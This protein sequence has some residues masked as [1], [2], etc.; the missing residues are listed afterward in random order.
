MKGVDSYGKNLEARI[1]LYCQIYEEVHK[2]V[3]G[4][5]FEN[6]G[7]IAGKIF[8]QIAKDLRR[9]KFQPKERNKQNQRLATEKQKEALHKFGVKKIPE[10]LSMREASKV[11]NRLISL[12]KENDR[13]SLDR[14]VGEL[15]KDWA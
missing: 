9:Q 5:N 10:N 15:N 12:S 2:R 7:E 11:L 3:S 13:A 1:G 4:L 14:A 6:A 8:E